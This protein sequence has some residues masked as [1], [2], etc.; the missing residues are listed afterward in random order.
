MK[1][2]REGKASGRNVL[3]E[4]WKRNWSESRSMELTISQ[5]PLIVRTLHEVS[6]LPTPTCMPSNS[7]CLF[8][9]SFLKKAT[10]NKAKAKLL[11]LVQCFTPSI[12]L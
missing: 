3:E 10:Q 11:G 8:L 12:N 2:G 9:L 7:S 6:T 1:T 4:E 5:L